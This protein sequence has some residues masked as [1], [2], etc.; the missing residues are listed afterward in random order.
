[1]FVESPSI[2]RLMLF[3]MLPPMDTD[4]L[5]APSCF[6]KIISLLLKHQYHYDRQSYVHNVL[7]ALQ[8]DA[9]ESLMSNCRLT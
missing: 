9:L 5:A 4:G 2:L 1:M 8:S 3:P 7:L 6:S